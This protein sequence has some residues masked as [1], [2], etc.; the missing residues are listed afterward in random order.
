MAPQALAPKH[1]RRRLIGWAAARRGVRRRDGFEEEVDF[2]RD[3]LDKH[4]ASV[5]DRRLW[6]AAF[7]PDLRRWT[8]LL[9]AGTPELEA[10][11]LGSGPVSL[12]AWGVDHGLFRLTAVDPLANEYATLMEAHGWS[13]PVTPI[14]QDGEN[15]SKLFGADRFDLA[16][17]SNALDHTRAP[18]RCIEEIAK[19]VRA[20]G[21][22]YCEGFVREGTNAGWS[23]LHQH[24]LVPENGHLVRY[25]QRAR[26]AVLTEGLGLECLQQKV[27]PFIER[28]LTSHGYEWSGEKGRDWRYDH[29]FTLVWQVKDRSRG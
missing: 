1:L 14:R 15:L 17:A 26:R 2:W 6:V 20:G 12:L 11:E 22:V 28:G 4:H 18:R 7:P 16:Y 9:A 5:S 27:Q 10:L 8:E 3:Y 19:V 29:W 23:G 21:L 25:D 24:D 13:Y